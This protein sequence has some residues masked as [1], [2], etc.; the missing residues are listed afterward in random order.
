M[1]D[2]RPLHQQ[3]LPSGTG[4]TEFRLRVGFVHVPVPYLGCTNHK[5]I[6]QIS[7]STE[8]QPWSVGT[9]YD[10]PIPRRLI[11]E[12]GVSRGMF[13][14]RKKAVAIVAEVDGGFERVMTKESFADFSSFLRE[15]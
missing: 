4:L 5:S 2:R 1:Q 9:R 10:K 7:T 6:H 8:M 14:T 15:H 12:A 11:E 13:G 3:K